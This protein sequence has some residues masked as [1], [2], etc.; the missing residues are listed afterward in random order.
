MRRSVRLAGLLAVLLQALVLAAPAQASSLSFL[1]IELNGSDI[2]PT[3]T[4]T[5]AAND[6][7]VLSIVVTPDSTGVTGASISVDFDPAQLQV[8]SGPVI[9]PVGFGNTV[10]GLCGT[11]TGPGGVDGLLSPTGTPSIDNIGGFVRN[12]AA[13]ASSG[14][15][16]GQLMPFTLAEMTFL[17]SDM[18]GTPSGSTLLAPTLSMNDGVL[19][20]SFTPVPFD[21]F[22]ASANVPVVP[23]PGTLLLTASGLGVLAL[24]GGRRRP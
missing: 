11:A 10:P 3:A 9:C 8:I 5:L 20:G 2:S 15:E 24:V 19:D 7:A 21:S 13:Q 17:A 18:L 22:G 12:N 1:W 14:G 16:P 23:E 6:T 4:V